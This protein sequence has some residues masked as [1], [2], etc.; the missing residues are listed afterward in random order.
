M[1]YD[2]TRQAYENA[3][4]SF[5]LGKTM[6]AV[7][8]T[9]RHGEPLRIEFQRLSLESDGMDRLDEQWMAEWTARARD[10][11]TAAGRRVM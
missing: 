2:A 5:L 6:K 8:E 1:N 4:V 9:L 10:A 11:M 7:Y 3:E